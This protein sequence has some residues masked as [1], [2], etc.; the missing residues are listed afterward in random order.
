MAAEPCPIVVAY[1]AGGR[2]PPHGGCGRAGCRVLSACLSTQCDRGIAHTFDTAPCPSMIRK[3]GIAPGPPA[4]PLLTSPLVYC[5][6]SQS[7]VFLHCTLQDK[8]QHSISSKCKNY[9]GLSKSRLLCWRVHDRYA[10]ANLTYGRPVHCCAGLVQQLSTENLALRHHLA[11]A[12]QAAGAAP[13]AGPGPP[14]PA[15]ACA[16][17]GAPAAV[18][19]GV[20]GVAPAQYPIAQ[21]VLPGYP[22][23]AWMPAL[24]LGVTPKAR[25]FSQCAGHAP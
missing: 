12:Q 5:L 9:S 6:S 2:D 1:D 23:M 8:A 14:T 13:P 15:G 20:P 21:A 19:P 7:N 10:A 24:P 17:P 25:G 11:A 22:P 3:Q 18:P 4:E 16:V